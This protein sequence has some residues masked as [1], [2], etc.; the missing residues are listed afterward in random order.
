M[1]RSILIANR[2]EIAV[3]IIRTCRTLGIRTVAVYSDADRSALHTQQAD[4]AVFI[5]DSAPASSYLNISAIIAA[6]QKTNCDAI[7]PGYGFLAEN[8]DFAQAVI[9][10]GILFIGPTPDAIRAMGDKRQAK[11]L[12]QDIPFVPG[13]YGDDQTDEQMITQAERIGYPIMIKATAGGGGKGMRLVHDAARLPDELTAARREAQQAFGD[14]S[15]M[16]ERAL[17]EPRHIEVQ[18][19]GDTS[20]NIIAIGEREC[21]IQRRHQK[22]IEETPSPALTADRR[23]A[24]CETAV[25]VGQQIGYVN[26]GTVEFLL[27]NQGDFYFMEMNTRLQVEHPV[28]EAVYGVDLVALQIAIAEGA[29]LADLL[30]DTPLSPNGH[31]VE[32]RVYAEDP[33]SGFLPATG[34]VAL[35]AEP[36][37]GARVDAGLRTGDAITPHYDP[38]IAKMISHAATRSQAIRQL[39]AALYQTKL[40]G[41]KNNIAYLRRVLTHPDH[42]AGNISTHF[43]DQHDALRTVNEPVSTTALIAVATQ[44]QPAVSHW[45]NNPNRPITHQFEAND[46]LYTVSLM[47]TNG[48]ITSAAV[49]GADAT[50]TLSVSILEQTEHT[51]HLEIN[52]LYQTVTLLEHAG[53]WWV[54]VDGVTVALRWC[55]P[56]PV[57]DNAASSGG[58]LRAPMPGQVI[59]VLVDVGQ[60]VAEGDALVVMEAMKMEHRITAPY[61]GTITAIYYTIGDTVQ[62]DETLLS[63]APLTLDE[64]SG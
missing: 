24:I 38:M 60:T 61:A 3:R 47:T 52:G 49:T 64:Q 29:T 63:L 41:V 15:I 59:Q 56:L 12:L 27:D 2:G 23:T 55:D 44:L 11:N 36:T 16:L 22:I 34:T 51:V 1:I 45:R 46:T 42:I 43:V 17:I 30:P 7:H 5:G 48:Q 40:F 26:A 10:A 33:A 53:R 37:N 8:A 28:T 58:S 21:S 14:N 4:V 25:A 39:D 35:W 31:A 18:I 54:H 57:P 32:V 20:G 19:L 50:E 62:A 9:D 13:Y 6:A